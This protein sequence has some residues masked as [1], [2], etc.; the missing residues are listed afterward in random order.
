[1]QEQN[2]SHL[3]N[4]SE[5]DYSYI[6]SLSKD[7]SDLTKGISEAERVLSNETRYLENPSAVEKLQAEH[8]EKFVE[9]IFSAIE[10]VGGISSF[11]FVDQVQNGTTK[12]GSIKA[13]SERIFEATLPDGAKI[14]VEIDLNSYIG[15]YRMVHDGTSEYVP[16]YEFKLKYAYP[17]ASSSAR[18]VQD[19]SIRQPEIKI[20]PVNEFMEQKSVIFYSDSLEI[21][22][23]PEGVQLPKF[24]QTLG[25]SDKKE[26]I[27]ELIEHLYRNSD[28]KFENT[29]KPVSEIIA[30]YGYAS[31]AE[32]YAK[33]YENK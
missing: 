4:E 1:M 11:R 13:I 31:Y 21:I 7:A 30:S 19:G 20:S 6:K 23:L 32:E 15:A 26:K 29:D 17:V 8:K 9:K 5:N 24:I 18:M 22:S 2:P 3:G 16:K 12:P 28:A 10:L 33:R 14:I 25:T 27:R